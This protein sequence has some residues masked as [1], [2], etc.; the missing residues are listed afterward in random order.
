MSSLKVAMSFLVSSL[1]VVVPALMSLGE[2]RMNRGAGRNVGK[3]DVVVTKIKF[4]RM[5]ENDEK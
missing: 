4:R 1:E 5:I 3:L 2:V